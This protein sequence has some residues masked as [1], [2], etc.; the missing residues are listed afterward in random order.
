MP[1]FQGC[2]AHDHD[3]EEADCGPAWSLHDHVDTPRVCTMHQQWLLM[4][5]DGWKGDLSGD[6][7]QHL[8]PPLHAT[9][10]TCLNEAEAGSVRSMFRP[11]A[12]RTQDP[13]RPLQSNEDDPE[14]LITIPFNG[15]V[16]IKAICLIGRP[17]QCS[18]CR[19]T[20]CMACRKC[21]CPADGM[22]PWCLRL[23][24]CCFF[25]P[26]ASAWAC[27]AKHYASPQAS[28]LPATAGARDG[29][30]LVHSQPKTLEVP[31]LPA[32]GGSNDGSA[33]AKVRAFV[34]RDALDFSS[35]AD[36]PPTQQWDL[37][38]S[39]QADMEYPTQ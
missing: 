20:G 24:G 36:M 39:G 21:M 10:V 3:C 18:L 14:L 31:S 2:C 37:Q 28:Q 22:A 7:S 23:S 32:T 11:W 38:E 19:A 13:E 9:Q 29:S 35:V 5:V 25:P 33:P 12:H 8:P 34:N 27:L 26:L 17:S 16:K 15:T 6:L 1:P 30:A 4:S